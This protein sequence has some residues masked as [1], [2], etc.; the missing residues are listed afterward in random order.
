[1]LCGVRLATALTEYNK[2]GV[3]NDELLAILTDYETIAPDFAPGAPRTEEEAERSQFAATLD[4]I[5]A[6]AKRRGKPEII[7]RV[8]ASLVQRETPV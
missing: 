2:G 1:M 7:D 3:P 5:V 8:R 6:E 4:Q